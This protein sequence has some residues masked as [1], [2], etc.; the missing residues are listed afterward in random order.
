M[1]I[2]AFGMNHSEMIL[3]KEEI[4]YDYIKKPIIPGIECV[5]EIVNP[6]NSQFKVGQKVIAMMGGRYGALI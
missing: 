5:G 2:K 1:K 4:K 3:R 6:S